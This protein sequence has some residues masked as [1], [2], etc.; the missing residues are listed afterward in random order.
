MTQ[1]A[2]KNVE[3]AINQVQKGGIVIIQDDKSRENEG[4]LVMAAEMVTGE[5]VNF[6][7]RYGCGLIC[8]PMLEERLNELSLPQMVEKNEESMRTAFTVSVDAIEGVH[9]GISA[10]ERAITIQKL[11]DPKARASDFVRPGHIFPLRARPNGVFERRGQTEA[12]ID[13][14]RIAG[15]YPAAMICEIMNEDGTM[16]RSED[17]SVYAKKHQ[18]PLITVQDIVDYRNEHRIMNY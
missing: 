6:F 15:L 11:I 8:T 2:V 16:A 5:K 9:T 17:L 7:A 18:L 13:L 3:K 12:S 1:T 10:Y 14:I 4:D